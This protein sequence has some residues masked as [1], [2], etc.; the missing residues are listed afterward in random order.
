[1]ERKKPYFVLPL[2]ITRYSKKIAEER[3]E[4]ARL[5]VHALKTAIENTEYYKETFGHDETDHSKALM[6]RLKTIATLDGTNDMKISITLSDLYALNELFEEE[7][8][9]TNIPIF[10]HGVNLL[11]IFELQ[12]RLDYFIPAVW[13][14]HVE[15]LVT[16]M[17]HNR[18]FEAL[19]ESEYLPKFIKYAH[20]RQRERSIEAYKH[21]NWYKSL[22]N[23]DIHARLSCSHTYA[24]PAVEIILA[25][26]IFN[27]EPFKPV[28]KNLQRKNWLPF[29]TYF[30]DIKEQEKSAFNLPMEMIEEYMPE[31][32]DSMNNKRCIIVN[33][34]PYISDN[35]NEYPLKKEHINYGV[36]ILK[37]VEPPKNVKVT[38]IIYG[39]L[40]AT[41][42]P[43]NLA[44]A[45]RL[46]SGKNPVP[47]II[48]RHK[49]V[50]EPHVLMIVVKATIGV[51]EQLIEKYGS[52]ENIGEKEEWRSV[53]EIEVVDAT[54]SYYNARNNSWNIKESLK[55][56][57]ENIKSGDED[58]DQWYIQGL[59]KYRTTKPDYPD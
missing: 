4:K 35:R 30:P 34:Q 43:V 10:T 16:N 25:E 53:K 21:T 47:F 5:N 1:M 13:N 50:K 58:S 17:F 32:A 49:S 45:D 8:N 37:A 22:H 24:N 14:D 11:H 48:P 9:L 52:I 33:G 44:I 51:N 40:F 36:L 56:A 18:T 29:Y 38:S 46:L 26:K 15:S 55:T 20:V 12:Q 27:V 39:S 7:L 41:Y 28:D 31:H 57:N 3:G 6:N 19:Q 42:A 23:N 2:L 59:G 54:L